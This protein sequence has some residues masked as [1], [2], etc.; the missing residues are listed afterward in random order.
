M[1]QLLIQELASGLVNGVA[2]G[3]I[4][5]AAITPF[6]SWEAPGMYAN[7]EVNGFGVGVFQTANQSPYVF[8][9]MEYHEDTELFHIYSGQGIMIFA[10]VEN[11]KIEEGTV[12]IVLVREGMQFSVSAG[13][14]HMLS[15]SADT[16]MV[17]AIAVGP[18]M[19]AYWVSLSEPVEGVLE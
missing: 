9:K 11:D 19:G 3:N 10:D 1:K 8:D 17:I 7:A 6:S 14:G 13:K 5:D 15:S 2:V 18:K 16:N 12:Q 4:V